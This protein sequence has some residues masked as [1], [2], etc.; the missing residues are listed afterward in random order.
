MEPVLREPRLEDEAQVWQAQAELAADDFPFVFSDDGD[1]WADLLARIERERVGDVPPERVPC[2]FLLATYEDEIVGRT[3]IRHE[4]NDV[5]LTTGGH[6]G[7]AVRPAWRRRG[8]AT[9]ILRQSLELTDRLG[10][11]RVLVTC[12]EGNVGSARVIES[13]GGVFG[14]VRE[15]PGVA[16]KRRYWIDRRAQVVAM[17]G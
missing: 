10:I 3:S 6:I 2:T 13:Q 14:D 17:G 1:T 5:L 4:L 11:E 12:D 16:P 7:Y 9:A 15:L 8:F